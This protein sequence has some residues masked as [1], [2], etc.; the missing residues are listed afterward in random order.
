MRKVPEWLPNSI[1]CNTST[2]SHGVR[3]GAI[4]PT[5]SFD[6][7]I[8]SRMLLIL[9]E[10]PALIDGLLMTECQIGSRQTQWYFFGYR[11][12][13]CGKIYLVDIRTRNEFDAQRYAQHQCDPS[14][15]RRATRNA[16]YLALERGEYLMEGHNG[17][18]WAETYGQ[19]NKQ[20]VKGG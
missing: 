7:S 6:V 16:R 3:S 1:L 20:F 8:P 4:M 2:V 15:L 14:E 10:A 17:D 13:G 5:E 9:F 18:W 11:C 12:V 19:E